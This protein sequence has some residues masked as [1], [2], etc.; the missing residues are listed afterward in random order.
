MNLSQVLFASRMFD[1]PFIKGF[2]IYTQGYL[3]Q[4]CN[5]CKQGRDQFDYALIRV[6]DATVKILSY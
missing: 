1:P 2:T 5:R 6:F 3:E 4:V